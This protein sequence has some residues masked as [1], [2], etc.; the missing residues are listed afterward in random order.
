MSITKRY[1][2]NS[3]QELKVSP[4][5]FCLYFDLDDTLIRNQIKFTKS[6][7]ECVKI[8]SEEI[9]SKRKNLDKNTLRERIK[10][11][12]ITLDL[13]KAQ[14]QHF[15][16]NRMESS[17]RQTY[18]YFIRFYKIPFNENIIMEINNIVRQ[19]WEPP[20]R[21]YEDVQETLE[22]LASYP[23]IKYQS[24][25]TLGAP[26]LQMKK[27]NSIPSAVQAYFSEF[28]VVSKK[29]ITTLAETMNGI[30]RENLIYIGN[31][32][33]SDIMPALELGV[34]AIHFPNKTWAYDEI[35][36]DSNNPNYY[37]ID[38][39]NELPRLLTQIIRGD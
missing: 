39:F 36:L 2:L 6:N 12:F 26:D 31:S 28:I 33:R 21:L 8:I 32:A 9:L 35:D 30:S 34:R 17:W 15:R 18:R 10:N 19:V 11:H 29:D 24:I 14:S 7:R 16:R 3:N 13:E 1:I 5:E 37:A 22:T 38:K 25:Y 20:F 4:G 27:F 23:E